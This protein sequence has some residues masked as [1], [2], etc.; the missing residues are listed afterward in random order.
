MA[1]T[2]NS[3]G[4]DAQH[5][6]TPTRYRFGVLTK[7]SL[8]QKRNKPVF[9]KIK[10]K[11]MKSK[12]TVTQLDFVPHKFWESHERAAVGCPSGR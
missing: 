8:A 6:L 4:L 2:S 10:N 5:S 11:K 3:S 1:H 9:K 12:S 7:L